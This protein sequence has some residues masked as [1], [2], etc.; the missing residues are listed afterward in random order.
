MNLTREFVE[1][2]RSV[3][4]QYDAEKDMEKRKVIGLRLDA[5][6]D[7]LSDGQLSQVAKMIMR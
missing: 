7:Q 4:R 5:M 6:A 1:G 3:A 2:M